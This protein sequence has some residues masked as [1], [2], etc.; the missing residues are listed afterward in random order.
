MV[1]GSGWNWNRKVTGDIFYYYYFIYFTGII[2]PNLTLS[3][4]ALVRYGL[5]GGLSVPIVSSYD[6]VEYKF[7]W[8]LTGKHD[9]FITFYFERPKK[10]KKMKLV[11]RQMVQISETASVS[12]KFQNDRSC[13][14][15]LDQL[16]PDLIYEHFIL[17]IS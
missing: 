9:F 15:D 12:H 16:S 2:V 4:S 8:K 7:S 5:Q 10:I 14:I 3:N 17:K 11:Q 6:L 1:V 13:F